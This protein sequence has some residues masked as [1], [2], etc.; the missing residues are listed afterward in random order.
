MQPPLPCPTATWH[1]DTYKAIEPTQDGLSQ[2]GKTIII[3][4]AGTGIGQQTAL[5]F[6]KAS[7]AHLVLIGRTLST[8][9]ATKD[10]VS[11]T[12]ASTKISVYT[13]SVTDRNAM[14]KIADE[15]G[16]WHVLVLG[17]A[18]IPP[19]GP[20]GSDNLDKYWEAYEVNVK[21]VIQITQLFLPTAAPPPSDSNPGA[22]IYAMGAGGFAFG[23]KITATLSAYLVS[24]IAQTKLIEYIAAENPGVAAITVH[25]GMVDTAVFRGAGADPAKLPMDTANLAADFLV[26]C[27]RSSGDGKR[28]CQF[29]NGKMVFA[30]WDVEELEA[31]AERIQSDEAFL[32]IGLGGWPFAA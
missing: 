27:S 19:P 32:T 6:A 4:G 3:T 18:S 31:M 10:L 1:N 13:A 22:I 5:S 21:S 8:L 2:E 12:N 29:L 9:S 23:A 28:P 24:K 11:A 30:N 14:R 15:V 20:L 16:A 17:A 26:W 25:P 7:A